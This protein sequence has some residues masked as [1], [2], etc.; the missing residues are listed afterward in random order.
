[1]ESVLRRIRTIVSR[2]ILQEARKTAY[3]RNRCCEIGLS[4]RRKIAEDGS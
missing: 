3:R 1:M 2:R 4:E